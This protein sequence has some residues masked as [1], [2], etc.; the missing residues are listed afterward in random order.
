MGFAGQAFYSPSALILFFLGADATTTGEGN[1]IK[2]FGHY[3]GY[4]TQPYQVLGVLTA[5]FAGFLFVSSIVFPKMYG[6]LQKAEEPC[7]N[8]P[9]HTENTLIEMKTTQVHQET[10]ETQSTSVVVEQAGPEGDLA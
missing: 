2:V 7:D 5:V 1:A 3:G 10:F 4:T 9:L 6:M 8:S